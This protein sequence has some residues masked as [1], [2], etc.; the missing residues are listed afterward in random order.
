MRQQ[1]IKDKATY[2]RVIIRENELHF[3][4]LEYLEFHYR[5]EFELA[6]K[7]AE[8]KLKK[9]KNKNYFESLK[10]RFLRYFDVLEF[11]KTNFLDF[12]REALKTAK[13][14]VP[15]QLKYNG[16]FV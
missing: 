5:D 4:M 15:R 3:F 14:N 6:S 2:W 7:Y 12:Y 13:H 1:T 16:S 9:Q 10:N 11:F 8:C